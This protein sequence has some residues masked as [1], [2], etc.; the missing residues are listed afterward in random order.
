MRVN[1]NN[2]DAIDP[3]EYVEEKREFLHHLSVIWSDRKHVVLN[4]YDKNARKMV[5]PWTRN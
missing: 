3:D 1:C 4:G 2:N 5:L